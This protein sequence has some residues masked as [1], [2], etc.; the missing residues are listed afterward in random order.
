M[1]W[2]VSGVDEGRLLADSVT[3][4]RRVAP[5]IA[6]SNGA[7]SVKRL[8]DEFPPFVRVT[9]T[10]NLG[11]DGWTA[12]TIVD[13][14]APEQG[15]FTLQIPL[16]PGESVLTANM[17]VRDGTIGV[18]MPADVGTVRWNSAVAV[19]ERV[20]LQAPVNS[21][22]V[23]T[24]QVDPS[25]LW[26]VTFSGTPEVFADPAMGQRPCIASSRGLVKSWN[27]ECCG[28]SRL[29]AAVSRSTS[30][31]MP[32]RWDSARGT[33]QWN[34]GIGAPRADDTRCNCRPLCA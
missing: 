26:R 18:S 1:Q 22:W 21:P 3:L 24:W 6:T 4:T 15:A 14:M 25:P 33:R 30:S 16:L 11:L 10:L 32:S 5:V 19:V 13:R 27:C 9:R 28:P 34:S 17:P 29:P 23:E 7:A 31:I 20:Q 12:S 2:T 8:T